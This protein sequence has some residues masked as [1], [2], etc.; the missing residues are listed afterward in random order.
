MIGSENFKYYLA[1]IKIEKHGSVKE[2]E[3]VVHI[4]FECSIS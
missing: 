2:A 1:N 3:T 4:V